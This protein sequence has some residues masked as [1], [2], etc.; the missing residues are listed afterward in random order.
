MS[1]ESEDAE[2]CGLLGAPS[3]GGHFPAL[4]GRDCAGVDRF[5]RRPKAVVSSRIEAAVSAGTSLLSL[6]EEYPA[7]EGTWIAIVRRVFR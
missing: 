7:D 3:S 2:H 4:S 1:R 6:E 5:H